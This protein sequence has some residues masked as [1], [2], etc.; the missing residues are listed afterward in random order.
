M[1]AEG[2][3][4][5][6]PHDAALLAMLRPPGRAN[7]TPAGRYDLVVLGGGPAGLV[8]AFGAAGLGASVALVERDLLGGDC[9]NAGCVPSKALIRAGR[10]AH[11]VN[12]GARF[13]VRAEAEVTWSEVIGRLRTTRAG[14]AVHDSVD[15]LEA[16]GIAVFLGAGAFAD[17]SS[18]EVEGQQIPFKRAVICTGA[19]PF[20]PP[21]PGLEA[22]PFL[23]NET[24]FALQEQ[25]KRLVVVGGGPIG[26][27]L[28][29]AFARLGTSVT[30]VERSERL[31]NRDDPDAAERVRSSMEADG[32]TLELGC[33]LDRVEAVSGGIRCHF[34]GREQ[35]TE[36]LL[37]AAG[38]RAR[39]DFAPER[40]GIE[41]QDR[42]VVVDDRL[43][44]HNPSVYAAGDVCGSWQFTHSADAMARIVVRN[45]FFPGSQRVSRLQVPWATYTDP[46]VAHI[47]LTA[48]AAAQRTDVH[49]WTADLADNDRATVDGHSGFARVHADTKGRVLGAT[50]C[51]P[52]AGEA[53]AEIA[54]GMRLGVRLSQIAST[55]H[56][57]P[58]RS[59]AWKRCADLS[60]RE[61]YTP[62]MK[63]LVMTWLRWMR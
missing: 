12:S 27:E 39:L 57:Y 38:R 36:H 55:V 28:A 20:V 29:Q 24:L 62:W 31:L 33:S 6:D 11:T 42:G 41:I 21:I 13:G 50:F 1:S 40:A 35:L 25:P 17:R 47:G 8:A 5:G 58:T 37:V 10:Q 63:R 9:L 56:P 52:D 15:R 26:C 32:V 22:A 4:A 34:D 3:V 49:T 18:V 54:L 14:I 30:L 16:A 43:R 48:A 44:T 61:R 46:E 51:G 19:R 23:T 2:L 60:M 45:A 7:P 59:E 53:I